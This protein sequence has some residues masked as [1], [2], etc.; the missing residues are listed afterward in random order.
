MRCV[1]A[2]CFSSFFL[3]FVCVCVM[4]REVLILITALCCL[5]FAQRMK[6]L[7]IKC[8]KAADVI[9]AEFLGS[10]MEIKISAL[11]V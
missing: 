1:L 4:A 3:V 8:Q 9:R 2:T 6:D 5:R 11:T 7:V 10:R